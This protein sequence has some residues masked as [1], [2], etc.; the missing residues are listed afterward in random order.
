M[1]ISPLAIRS[2][3]ASTARS[4]SPGGRALRI[5]GRSVGCG[6]SSGSGSSRRPAIRPR[7]D[8]RWRR[9]RRPGETSVDGQEGLVLGPTERDLRQ[10]QR[11]GGKRGPGWRCGA[12]G[13]EGKPPGPDR[14][15]AGGQTYGL[16]DHRVLRRRRHSRAT[17]PK[18]SAP[19]EV[20]FVR[21]AESGQGEPPVRLLP[22]E[23]VVGGE[24][25]GEDGGAGIDPFDRDGDADQG[26]PDRAGRQLRALAQPALQLA[27]RRREQSRSRPS[28][29]SRSGRG[30]G[31]SARRPRSC[32]PSRSPRSSS[33]AARRRRS[34]PGRSRRTG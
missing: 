1:L 15:G 32:R 29:P 25:R 12:L 18:R 2:V 10:G 30:G 9:G 23:P 7:S 11:R 34:S 27:S 17:S 19:R 4:K 26:P 6:S 33:S 8:R 13:V 14:A 21:D 5:C 22:A 3:A 28:G 20:A 24:A 16:L 31:P